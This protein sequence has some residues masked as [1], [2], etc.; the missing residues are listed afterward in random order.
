MGGSV[1]QPVQIALV[2]L[3]LGLLG[4]AS[5]RFLFPEDAGALVVVSADKAIRQSAQGG[6]TTLSPGDALAVR[7]RLR[8][9][10]G[11]FAVIRSNE[12]EYRIEGEN[13]SIL[14]KELDSTGMHVEFEGGRFSAHVREGSPALKV[15][16]RGRGVYA[17][18]ADFA[19]AAGDDGA[20]SVEATRG[21]LELEG[22][23]GAEELTAGQRVSHVPGQDAVRYDIPEQLLLQVNGP[24]GLVT[25]ETQVA[26]SG[27]T[28]PFASV[29]IGGGSSTKRIRAGPDGTFTASV[30]LEADGK[31]TLSVTASDQLGRSSKQTELVVE[32]RSKPPSGSSNLDYR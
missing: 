28:S 32:K 11:G 14:I 9:E 1:K 29:S 27:S 22:M 31:H 15:S 12:S 20:L 23:A 5:Y 2:G 25:R 26:V 17:T 21:S 8:T 13:G 7:D 16:N 30:E 10:A 19:M 3:I 18:N 4:F 6:S 24:A